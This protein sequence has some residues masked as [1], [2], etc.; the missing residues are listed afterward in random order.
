MRI[1]TTC[2]S[3]QCISDFRAKVA[4]ALATSAK[5]IQEGV[6]V[7]TFENIKKPTLQRKYLYTDKWVSIS[8]GHECPVVMDNPPLAYWQDKALTTNASFFR[9]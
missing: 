6:N 8:N 4:N 3:W 2:N 5:F 9:G 1:F 7:V